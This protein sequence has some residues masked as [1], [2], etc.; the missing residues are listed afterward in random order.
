MPGVIGDSR[1]GREQGR[2]RALVAARPL[3]ILVYMGMSLH[4]LRRLRP[5]AALV[6]AL[7]FGFSTA[8][9]LLADV[10][11]GDATHQE[12]TRLEGSG[13]HAASHVAHGDGENGAMNDSP[14]HPGERSSGEEGHDQH[15]CHHAHAHGGWFRTDQVLDGAFPAGHESPLASRDRIPASRD[16]QPQL[17][18]P[19]D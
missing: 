1:R 11:D 15:A 5:L 4:R 10:H 16:A 17:R 9:S 2:D 14:E 12:L 13:R 8:E 7:C 19:I 3:P 6:L 18:P